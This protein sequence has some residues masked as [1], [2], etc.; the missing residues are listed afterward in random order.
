MLLNNSYVVQNMK[1]QM[2]TLRIDTKVTKNSGIKL[3][4]K[5]DCFICKC[6]RCSNKYLYFKYQKSTSIYMVR[7]VKILVWDNL[8]PIFSGRREM[9]NK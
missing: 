3:P 7:H 6:S 1:I 4:I 8:T 5:L 9:L 2:K